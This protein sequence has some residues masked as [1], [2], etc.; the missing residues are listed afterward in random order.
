MTQDVHSHTNYITYYVYIY[1][2]SYHDRET[3]EITYKT[4]FFYISDMRLQF[5]YKLGMCDAE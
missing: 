4:Y 5:S 1:K 3:K 2:L